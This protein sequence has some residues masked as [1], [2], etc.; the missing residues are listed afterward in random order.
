MSRKRGRL[1]ASERERIL[2][3][4]SYP[5]RPSRVASVFAAVLDESVSKFVS[6]IESRFDSLG[7]GLGPTA[8]LPPSIKSSL[9][10]AVSELKALA[11]AGEERERHAENMRLLVS[12]VVDNYA[13]Q[14]LPLACSRT[15]IKDTAF[16][17]AAKELGRG[18]SGVEDIYYGRRRSKK[19][20][21]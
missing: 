2:S 17:E 3:D 19:N 8:R 21:A 20:T 10:R 5:V 9:A 6:E 13:R 18:V 14:G 12:G 15:S 1:K 4:G 7:A 16:E 11:E